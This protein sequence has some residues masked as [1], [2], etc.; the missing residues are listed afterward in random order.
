MK[1]DDKT[2]KALKEFLERLELFE[3]AM[4]IMS[5]NDAEI[6]FLFTTLHNH[7]TK[8]RKSVKIKLSKALKEVAI[9]E[10]KKGI[11]EIDEELKKL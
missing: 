3:E 1:T 9:S 8:S 2:K 6:Y 10:V 5:N 7:N 4:D 11:T